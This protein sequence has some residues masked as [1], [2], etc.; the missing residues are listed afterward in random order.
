MR[1][2]RTNFIHH[3]KKVQGICFGG[4]SLECDNNIVT[5]IHKRIHKITVKKCSNIKC[6]I[7]KQK[8]CRHEMTW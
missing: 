2:N 5:E 1:K 7:N 8:L 4:D 3:V 6:L